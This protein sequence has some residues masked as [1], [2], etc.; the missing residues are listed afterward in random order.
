MGITL[1]LSS[2]VAHDGSVLLFWGF[3]A[4]TAVGLAG[5]TSL[6]ELSS[7]MP[8]AGGQYIWVAALSPPGPRRFL[9][10]VT[11][12]LSWAGA[13]CT[14]ASVCVVGPELLFSL[15]TGPSS[16]PPY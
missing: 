9:S 13:V 10:Y 12:I 16:R 3:I 8:D 7:A 4:M 11:A 6:A 14:G 5:A 1:V 15:G 2:V